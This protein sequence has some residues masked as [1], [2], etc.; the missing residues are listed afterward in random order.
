[1][2]RFQTLL[3]REWLQHKFAWSLMVLIPLTLGLMLTGVGEVQFDDTPP[4]ELPMLV[5]LATVAGT[6]ISLGVIAAIAALITI[7]GLARRDHADRSHEFWLSM[8]IGHASAFSAPLLVHLL[9]VPVAAMAIG[10][11]AGLVLSMVLTSRIAGF[12]AW[13]SLPWGTIVVGTLSV[14]GRI[15]AGLPLALLWLSPL[16]LSVVLLCAWFRRWGLVIFAVALLAAALAATQVF[17]SPWPAET[18]AA[19]VRQAGLALVTPEDG[20]G[21][22]VHN[23]EDAMAAL[24]MAPSWAAQNFGLALTR[25]VSPLLLGGLIVAAGCFVALMDWRRRGVGGAA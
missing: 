9:I 4:I 23:G 18:V 12:G 7:T 3:L 25:L 17:G 5:T 2:S 22:V 24:A 16:I 15:A 1:M 19:I 21:M 14:I 11:L 8:P 20:G 10:W 13:L 6:S